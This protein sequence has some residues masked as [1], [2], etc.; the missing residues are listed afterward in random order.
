ML[1]GGSLRYDD[2]LGGGS[3]FWFE[4][5]I[6]DV[7]PLHTVD[8]SSGSLGEGPLTEEA[9]VARALYVLVVDD[10]PMNRDIATA[11]LRAGGHTVRCAE[12]GEAAIAEASSTDFDVVLMDVRMPGMDGLEATRRIRALPGARGRVPI[13]AVTAQAFAEQVAD[14]R[15]AG[16]GVHLGKPFDQAKLLA[17][18]NLAADAGPVRGEDP[19]RAIAVAPRGSPTPDTGFEL[20]VIERDVFEKT[21]SSLAPAAAEAYLRT[22][23]DLGDALLRDLRGEDA[24]TRNRDALVHAAHTMAGSAGMFGFRRVSEIGRNFERAMQSGPDEQVLLAE[25]LNSAIEATLLEVQARIIER[26]DH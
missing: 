18:V 2:N 8:V 26:S 6:G 25:R 12:S 17:A 24:L 3:V 19:V 7:R 21:A 9:S 16:M 15:K 13:V 22:I 20:P 23:A 1:M 10:V 14:C 4:L 11:F 5:P